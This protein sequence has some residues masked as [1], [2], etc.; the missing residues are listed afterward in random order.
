[1][2]RKSHYLAQAY[3]KFLRRSLSEHLQKLILFGSQ[4]RGDAG[5]GSDYDMAIIVDKRTSK[6][7]DVVLDAEVR[8]MDQHD[9]LFAS[10]I[11]AEKEWKRLQ[12]FPLA[13]NIRKEGV[14]LYERK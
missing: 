6:I 12:A 3:A 7:H 13:W 5:E 14:I 2:T 10:L 8:M 4:A 1:M 9:K 11:Y